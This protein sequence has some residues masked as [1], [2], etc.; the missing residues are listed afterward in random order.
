MD[1]A[2]RSTSPFPSLLAKDL[3]LALPAVIVCA[4][5]IGV[6]FAV[7]ALVPAFGPDAMR[8]FAFRADAG[9]LYR[10]GV[11]SPVA[12]AALLAAAAAS[13]ALMAVGDGS[14][15][16]AAMFA[17]VPASGAVRILSKVAATA[18]VAAAFMLAAELTGGENRWG[19]AWCSD[20][21]ISYGTGDA[22]ANRRTFGE[23]ERSIV[24]GLHVVGFAAWGLACGRFIR[25]PG[26]AVPAAIG[27]AIASAAAVSVASRVGLGLVVEG[28]DRW[29]SR[30]IDPRFIRLPVIQSPSSLAW[31]APVRI[32]LSTAATTAGIGVVAASFAFGRLAGGPIDRR[33]R[34]FLV[35]AGM[36]AAAVVAGCLAGLPPRGGSGFDYVR[37]AP[38]MLKRNA[39]ARQVASA[40][41]AARNASPEAIVTAAC[42]GWLNDDVCRPNQLIHVEECLASAAG[43][44]ARLAAAVS[45]AI[46]GE[47]LNAADPD[48]NPYH[49]ASPESVA[50]RMVLAERC[51]MDPAPIRAA[52]EALLRDATGRVTP[53]MR[54]EA[55]AF[56]GPEALGDLAARRIAGATSEADRAVGMSLL[57]SVDEL[58]N[59]T[60]DA[61]GKARVATTASDAAHQERWR[62]YRRTALRALDRL[63][64]DAASRARQ[65]P[66]FG[67]LDVPVAVDVRA[68]ETARAVLRAPM[69]GLADAV[70]ANWEPQGFVITE[71]PTP[72]GPGPDSW[73][74]LIGRDVASLRLPASDLVP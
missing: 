9:L 42:D 15:G 43:M 6:C 53:G 41:A 38:R 25:R 49:W 69:P 72:A 34:R 21:E 19:I 12:D 62:W 45:R 71:Q 57:S 39:D 55:A 74:T 58:F 20:L 31:V 44:N 11:A 67:G 27:L 70:R 32:D 35:P 23:A 33:M 30:G 5:V 68:I 63:Q 3:R 18:I 60:L 51:A 28:I 66:A 8:A 14:R 59:V 47:G 29:D 22:I 16:A 7:L 56:L 48:L 50:A 10:L 61:S 40:Y 54:I 65:R 52:L 24:A 37:L 2:I 13:G 46:R 73:E 4:S 17:T 1:I 64:S 26:W 36:L